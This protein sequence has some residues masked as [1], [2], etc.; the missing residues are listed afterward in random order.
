MQPRQV[1][2]EGNTEDPNSNLLLDPKLGDEKFVY[3]VSQAEETDL[4]L[5]NQIRHYGYQVRVVGGMKNLEEV[6]PNPK[7][8]SIIIDVSKA[9][10]EVDWS[11]FPKVPHWQ[12]ASIPIIFISDID[13]QPL[14]LKAL[15]AGGIAFFHKPIDAVHLVDKLEQINATR[16]TIPY[17][18]LVIEDQPA[19]A[20]YYQMIL[21]NFRFR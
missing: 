8:V 14:R 4:S 19:I 3:L 2:S 9:G 15:H 12:Q 21:K 7:L 18:V 6:I 5:A 17:R 1:G 11:I 10:S 13:N 16:A 20:G